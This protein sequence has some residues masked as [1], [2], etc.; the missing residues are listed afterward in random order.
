MQDASLSQ[1]LLWATGLSATGDPQELS[2]QGKRMWKYSTFDHFPPLAEAVPGVL[3]PWLFWPVLLSM[4]SGQNPC[5]Q[6]D[7]VN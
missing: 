3:I 1:L 4:L 2:H 7:L 6:G 5:R